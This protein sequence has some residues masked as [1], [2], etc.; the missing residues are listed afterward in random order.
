MS[1]KDHVKVGD[2][3]TFQ[4]QGYLSGM[5]RKYKVN[6]ITDSF[7][8]CFDDKVKVALDGTMLPR[9]KYVNHIVIAING[10]AFDSWKGE[11]T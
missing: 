1:V 10:K 4:G 11:F 6:R 7:I 2:V 9:D 8:F 3:L 5:V